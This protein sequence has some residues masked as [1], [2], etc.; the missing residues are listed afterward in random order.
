MQGKSMKKNHPQ[1]FLAISLVGAVLCVCPQVSAEE[2]WPLTAGT[3]DRYLLAGFKADLVE[4][5]LVLTNLGK[6][7][8]HLSG[9][10]MEG[11]DWN[12]WGTRKHENRGSLASSE[13]C[14]FALARFS[15]SPEEERLE[16]MQ[17]EG[18]FQHL[19]IKVLYISQPYYEEQLDGLSVC[20]NPETLECGNPNPERVKFPSP[21]YL[22]F[23]DRVF[24]RQH[25]EQG[26]DRNQALLQS[27]KAA[28]GSLDAKLETR[29]HEVVWLTNVEH[30]SNDVAYYFKV[31]TFERGRLIVGG[32]V[33][34]S[35]NS[36]ARRIPHG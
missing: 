14:G 18:Y 33:F 24:S 15:K 1:T 36:S 23:G 19:G 32:D 11:V 28:G 12:F 26:C 10:G 27:A 35:S 29:K 2:A 30:P 4:P 31:V 21:D 8:Q 16:A 9:I 3:K 22:T 17:V 6:L 13:Y 20:V 25:I 5:A 7:K 34:Y